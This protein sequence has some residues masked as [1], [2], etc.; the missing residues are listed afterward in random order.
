MAKN[1][2]TDDNLCW[3]RCGAKGNTSAL[4]V[5]VQTGIVTVEISMVISLKIRKQPSSKHSN[6]TFS[7]NTKDAQLCHKDMRSTMF[8]AALLVIART[9]KQPKCSSTEE[10]IKKMWYIFTRWSTTQQEK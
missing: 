9:W 10:Q 5:G 6:T 2:N 3:R 8:I 7:Y 4:L 1:K